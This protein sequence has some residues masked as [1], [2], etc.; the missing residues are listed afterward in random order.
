[1][2]SSIAK[3]TGVD[4]NRLCL[5][6]T[7]FPEKNINNYRNWNFKSYIYICYIKSGEL[8][9]QVGG[10]Q[11]VRVERQVQCQS[12]LP[13]PGQDWNVGCGGHRP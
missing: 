10:R 7:N 3:I 1:M 5:L 9:D 2:T 4:K 8:Q 13:K 11:E 12:P 6:S